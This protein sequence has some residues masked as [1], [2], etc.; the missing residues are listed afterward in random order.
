MREDILDDELHL[1]KAKSA[2]NAREILKLKS[3]YSE[4]HPKVTNA[5]KALWWL[6]ALQALG[7][8]LIHI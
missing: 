1:P 3:N 2:E 7:L 5:Q 8:S 4:L 6:V